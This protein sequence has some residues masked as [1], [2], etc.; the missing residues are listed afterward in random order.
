MTQNDPITTS[1]TSLAPHTTL[2]VGGPASQIVEAATEEEIIEQVQR[3]DDSDE[4]LLIL[5]GGS[6]VV[7]AAGGWPGAALLIRSRGIEQ[8]DACGAS[9]FTVAA[10]ES[11][12]DFVAQMVQEG[13]SGI[14]ALSGVPGLVG[15]TPIQNVGA[16]GQEVSETITRVRAWDRDDG[17][18]VQLRNE[19]CGFSYRD[20][21]FKRDP[22]RFVIL[23]VTFGLRNSNVSSPIRYGQLANALGVGI[24]DRAPL[25]DTRDLVLQLR[26]EKGMVCDPADPDTRSAGSFFMNP[27]L[28]TEQA[29][30]LPD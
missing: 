24:G 20:S 25:Q 2:Q 13:Y 22:D 17:R 6:N 28:T 18:V 15:A 3:F 8:A 1:A 5:G 30:A 29:E 23:G 7:I 12:D 14:E 9:E 11:W 10:G 4:P 19:D 27:I 21:R 16:Y 26:R